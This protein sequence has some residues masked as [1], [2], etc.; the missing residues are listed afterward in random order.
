MVEA[1]QRT[2]RIAIKV[3]QL[4]RVDVRVGLLL[5]MVLRL[6]LLLLLLITRTPVC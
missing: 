1:R 6:L 4:R 2:A 3:E 5:L